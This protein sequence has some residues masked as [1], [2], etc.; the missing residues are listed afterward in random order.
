MRHSENARFRP[1]H[2]KFSNSK[3]KLENFEHFHYD[4]LTILVPYAELAFIQIQAAF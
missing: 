2:S 3:R 1:F 4:E